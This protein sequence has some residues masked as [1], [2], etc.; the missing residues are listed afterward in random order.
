MIEIHNHQIQKGMSIR[1][2]IK[3]WCIN[4]LSSE[5]EQV[6]LIE[7]LENNVT[8]RNHAKGVAEFHEERHPLHTIVIGI[9]GLPN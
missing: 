1:P 8:N 3:V 5:N 4:C 7:H 2:G 9:F 6:F